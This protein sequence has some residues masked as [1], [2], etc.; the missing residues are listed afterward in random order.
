MI[1]FGSQSK[2]KKSLRFYSFQYSRNEFVAIVTNSVWFE[3][4]RKTVNFFQFARN[5]IVVIVTNSVWFIIRRKTVTAIVFLPLG[6]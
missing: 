2:G 6:S 4:I 1:P 3:I 5:E